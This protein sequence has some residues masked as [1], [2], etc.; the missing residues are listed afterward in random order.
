M[1]SNIKTHILIL[2]LLP[3]FFL[4]CTKEPL[5]KD[6]SHDEGFSHHEGHFYCSVSE[7]HNHPDGNITYDYDLVLKVSVENDSIHFH[8]YSHKVTHFVFPINS[9]KQLFFQNITTISGIP[10][11]SELRFENNFDSIII[12]DDYHYLGYHGAS[13]GRIQITGHKT[14]LEE[15]TKE[16]ADELEGN[17]LLNITHNN[18]ATQVET[19]HL[20]RSYQKIYAGSKILYANNFHS[21]WNYENYNQDHSNGNWTRRKRNVVWTSHDFSYYER[22]ISK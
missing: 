1:I 4:A 12:N 11:T 16:S 6:D 8:H 7:D 14:S 2:L 9:E 5:P 13:S 21:Y 19:R 18:M 3:F 15:T 17:Y 10:Q 22:V 20:S